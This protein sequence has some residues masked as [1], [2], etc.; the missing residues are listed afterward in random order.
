MHNS[1]EIKCEEVN[2][3]HYKQLPVTLVE[4]VKRRSGWLDGG[5]DIPG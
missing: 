1:G 2:N 3:P 4:V 5:V